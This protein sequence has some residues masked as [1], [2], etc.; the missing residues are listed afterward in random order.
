MY[1]E[2]DYKKANKYAKQ[3]IKEFPNNLLYVS[4]DIQTLLLL[5]KYNK[6]KNLI[7]ELE[8]HSHENNFFQVVAEIYK[9][10]ISEKKDK[11][12]AQAEK[13]YSD[14][15]NRMESY[16]EFANSYK[17]IAYFGLSRIYSTKDSNR[18]RKY[19][20]RALDL[21]VYPRINFD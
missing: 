9:G 14:A 20:K 16:G 10:I 2:D 21:A 6:A 18:S 5:N 15:I 1:F 13:Y 19:K 7:Q 4:Y 3:L 12:F 17:S 11:D 8:T